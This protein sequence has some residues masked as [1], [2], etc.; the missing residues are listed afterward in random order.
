MHPNEKLLYSFYSHL[1]RLNAP[2]MCQCYQREVVFSDPIFPSLK[3]W[4]AAAMWHML[5]DRSAEINVDVLDIHADDERGVAKW[6]A[7]YVYSDTGRPVHNIITSK[8]KFYQGKVIRQKD[9]FDLWRWSRMALGAKGVLL[10]WSSAFQEKLR[11]MA[12]RR[13]KQYIRKKTAVS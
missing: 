1:G 10:G 7:R 12:R 3:S 8:F 11:Q 6:E 5:C 4:E 9:D 13:L 2:G